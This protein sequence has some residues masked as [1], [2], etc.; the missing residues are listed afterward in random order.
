MLNNFLFA[1]FF[2]GKPDFHEGSFMAKLFLYILVAWKPY[3][4]MWKA[5]LKLCELGI[6]KER[7]K[8]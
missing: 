4:E 3:L 5:S 2:G 6:H 1:H 8:S 7:V